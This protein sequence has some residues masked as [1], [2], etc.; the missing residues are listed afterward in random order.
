MVCVDFEVAYGYQ[1]SIVYSCVVSQSLGLLMIPW[2]IL[3]DDRGGR[4]W[5]WGGEMG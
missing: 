1:T 5:R 4:A 2:P 3:G